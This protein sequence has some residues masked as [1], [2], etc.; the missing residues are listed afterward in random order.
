MVEG[1]DKATG[2]LPTGWAKAKL[3]EYLFL[4]NGF[5]FKSKDYVSESSNAVPVI[6]ISDIKSGCVTSQNA[7]QVPEALANPNFTITE[8][9]LLIAM[10]GAT[11]GKTGVYRGESVAYQNQRVGN[12]KLLSESNGH[13]GFRNYLI[14]SLSESILKEA[15][16]AA[17]PNISGKAIESFVVSLPPLNEQ[18]RIA[19]KLDTLLADVDRAQTRLACIPNTLKRFRQSVLAAATSGELT[20]EWREGNH[21]EPVLEQLA[22]IEDPFGI[23]RSSTIEP[24]PHAWVY[25][26]MKD[27]GAYLGGG[28]P[29]KSEE[30][31]WG[32][33]I[34][35]VTPKDMK[36][37]K[38]SVAQMGI[39]EVGLEKSS[40]KLI[41]EGAILFVVRG[42]ILAHSFPTAISRAEVT[43][44]QDM[45][46]LVPE[47]FILSEY[48]QIALDALKDT[49]VAIAGSSTHG[50]KRLETNKLGSV[51]IPIPPLKEQKQIVQRV[52]ELFA[53]ADTVEKQYNQAKARL[54]KLTQSILA[55]A[56]RGELVPQDPNDEPASELLERI[57]TELESL[58]NTKGKTKKKLTSRKKKVGTE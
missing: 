52:E 29:K 24:L 58:A 22:N 53:H 26:P 43:I 50:T 25:R 7:A 21:G 15:Y 40:A 37:K 56:F 1:A 4:K 36:V 55:K 33:S 11:T 31:F 19:D 2:T 16:G 20:K 8:G 27:C 51:G 44:N 28:T 3:G 45:K 47:S 32:G 12:I 5:A 30:S 34:P 14:Q 49:F 57:K 46:A 17:Q 9:D 18:K 13:K 41:P 23:W 39:T 42:M 54:D 38:I 35:W 10:S 48:A 6:R